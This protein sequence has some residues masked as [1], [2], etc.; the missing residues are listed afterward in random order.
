[1]CVCVHMFLVIS[2]NSKKNPQSQGCECRYP[3]WRAIPRYCLNYSTFS[4]ASAGP[5]WFQV[6]HFLISLGKL[7]FLGISGPGKQSPHPW[8]RIYVVLKGI[9]WAASSVQLLPL[10]QEEAFQEIPACTVWGWSSGSCVWMKRNTK[11][12]PVAPKSSRS[13]AHEIGHLSAAVSWLLS[14]AH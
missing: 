5:L 13:I 11:Y 2:R 10:M 14:H 3:L 6:I 8:D 9:K 12:I 1:M 7:L 4:I